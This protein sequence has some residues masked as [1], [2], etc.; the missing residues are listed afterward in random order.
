MTQWELR[1]RELVN[2]NCNYG[3]P[4]Q[5]TAPPTHGHCQ[6]VAAAQIDQGHYGQVRLDGLRYAMI[7]QWPGA[8]HEGHGRCQPIV[9]ERAD[10]AQR[11]AMLRILSGEDTDPF[12]TVFAVFATTFEEVYEPLFRSIDFEVDVEGRVGRLRVDGVAEM[13]GE[14]IR[15]PLSGEEFRA[16]IN[17]PDGFEYIYAEMG[18][19]S[20]QTSGPIALDLKDSYAQFADLHL[21]NHGI[22]HA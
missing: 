5:F 14:P 15:N 10:D 21:N 3:C 20:S 19:A 13:H 18:S 6:A 2:C 4:C 9:D 12:A 11:H 17:L 22:V 8:I 1:G 16:R 7:L